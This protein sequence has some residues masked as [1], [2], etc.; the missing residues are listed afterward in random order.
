MRSLISC[1]YSLIH[2]VHFPEVRLGR[3]PRDAALRRLAKDATTRPG[4]GELAKLSPRFD[5]PWPRFEEGRHPSTE[6]RPS[7]APRVMLCTEQSIRQLH[8]WLSI[9]RW[10]P[11]WCPLDGIDWGRRPRLW[12]LLSG[13]PGAP[14][15]CRDRAIP[16][17]PAFPL[18]GT[19]ET[20]RV[21]HVGIRHRFAMKDNHLPGER[22][23]AVTLI[24]CPSTARTASSKPSHPPGPAAL[25]VSRLMAP[26]ADRSKDAHRWSRCPH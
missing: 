10:S 24:C 9:V 11:R 7:P 3:Q 23:A 8:G 19:R 20:G 12:L 15:A 21:R 22:R 2:L 14:P 25:G 26:T 17:P 16:R 13:P 5:P 4:L 6:T 1:K 18:W